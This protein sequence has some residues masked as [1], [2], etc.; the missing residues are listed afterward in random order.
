MPFYINKFKEGTMSRDHDA[1]PTK[2]SKG[3]K[4][5]FLDLTITKDNCRMFAVRKD[6]YD[7]VF[8][9]ESLFDGDFNRFVEGF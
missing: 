5:T 9:T 4:V 2:L 1:V 6:G 7:L 8:Y 3:D